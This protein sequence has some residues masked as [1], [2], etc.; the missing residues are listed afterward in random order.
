V[1]DEIAIGLL[2]RHDLKL[3][4]AFVVSDPAE[5]RLVSGSVV[6]VA[7]VMAITW[8][9]DFLPTRCLREPRVNRIGFTDSIVSDTNCGCKT[10]F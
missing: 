2:D 6:M 3:S 7:A 9:A 1:D 5:R 8:Y 10:Q 4:T